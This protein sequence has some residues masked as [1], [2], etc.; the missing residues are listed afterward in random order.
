MEQPKVQS[1][2]SF[3]SYVIIFILTHQRKKERSPNINL[4]EPKLC[5]CCLYPFVFSKDNKNFSLKKKMPK[6]KSVKRTY[7][8]IFSSWINNLENT[9]TFLGDMQV[10]LFNG[11]L[12]LFTWTQQR[13]GEEVNLSLLPPHSAFTM[14]KRGREVR[15]RIFSL[16][17]A[18]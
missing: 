15:A 4:I 17:P 10:L 13:W 16:H 11:R 7:N 3:T 9:R 6:K 18:Q 8:G 5:F 12:R 14:V 2:L 1:L